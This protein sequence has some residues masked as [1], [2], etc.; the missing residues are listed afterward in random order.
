MYE[1]K[2]MKKAYLGKHWLLL[3]KRVFQDDVTNAE[4]YAAV[5]KQMEVPS[6]LAIS[7]CM[8]ECLR[9]LIKHNY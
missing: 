1:Y 9:S 3:N 5:L 6:L 4:L 7:K 2:H 8:Y